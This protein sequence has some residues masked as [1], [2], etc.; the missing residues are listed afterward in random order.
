M[1]AQTRPEALQRAEPSSI[2][3]RTCCLSRSQGQ[4][5]FAQ[6]CH[7]RPQRNA[8]EGEIRADPRAR[9]PTRNRARHLR[10]VV[11][12]PLREKRGQGAARLLL[13]AL[14][15]VWLVG[16]GQTQI[17]RRQKPHALHSIHAANSRQRVRRLAH[18]FLPM[19]R[20]AIARG[21]SPHHAILPEFCPRNPLLA[22]PRPHLAIPAVSEVATSFLVRPKT[23]KIHLAPQLMQHLG[24]LSPP[25]NHAPAQLPQ[26]AIQ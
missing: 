11:H 26:R 1:P 10:S 20:P 18:E 15:R 16:S 12:S 4:P 21:E 22:A 2:H 24:E 25:Q 19:P 17:L 9:G 13:P 6:F 7:H 8:T 23:R 14:L 5:A 3:S